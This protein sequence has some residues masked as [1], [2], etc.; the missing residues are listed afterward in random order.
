MGDALKK[1][2]FEVVH[3]Y[4]APQGDIARYGF[5]K[6]RHYSSR[7][8]FLYP[9]TFICIKGDKIFV[10]IGCIDEREYDAE[11]CEVRLHDWKSSQYMA[12]IMNEKRRIQ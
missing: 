5:R 1:I 11:N 10:R 3:H 12:D 9:G 6:L 4:G 2:S 8:S 7:C